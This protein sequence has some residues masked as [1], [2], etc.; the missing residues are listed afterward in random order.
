MDLNYKYPNSVIYNIWYQGRR[1]YTGSSVDFPQRKRGHKSSYNNN[2]DRPLYRKL[3]EKNIQFEDLQ[4]I[5]YKE[6]PCNDLKE[7]RKEE[8]KCIK[9]LKSEF[10]EN[11]AGRT[12][13]EYQKDN[14]EKLKEYQNE[15]QENNKEK[16]KEKRKE[17]CEKNKE[18]QKEYFKEYQKDNKEKIKEYQN[19]YY[20][21]NKEKLKEK[22]ICEC[23]IE[24][25]KHHKARHEKSQKHINYMLNKQ[26]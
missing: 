14:K 17:Y 23:G 16:L 13:K 10:N 9:E 24:Y 2:K 11:I 22:I 26:N 1:L 18:Y 25:T 6:F 7:L 15:Y 5:I 4:F 8:G 12:K 20:G 21:V 19:E 3:K